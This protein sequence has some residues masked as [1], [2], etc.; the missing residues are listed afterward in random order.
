MKANWIK[1]PIQMDFACPVFRKQINAEKEIK[2]ATITISARGIYEAT[3]NGKRIGDFIF[4]PGCTAYDYQ[5]QA[6]TYDITEDFCEN[7]TIDI[8]LTETEKI[9]LKHMHD[10]LSVPQIA[11]I[12]SCSK[13]T[14]ENH[15][16]NICKKIDE[17]NNVEYIDKKALNKLLILAGKIFK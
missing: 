13:Y 2:K 6:Q 11:K 17:L 8:S 12:L 16:K 10:G 1:S 3:L 5:I 15:K 14:I 9:I 4:A 7:N